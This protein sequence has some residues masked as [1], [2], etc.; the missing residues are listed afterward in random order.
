MSAAIVSLGRPPDF[1]APTTVATREQFPFQFMQ[2]FVIYGVID[3]AIRSAALEVHVDLP[4]GVDGDVDRGPFDFARVPGDY[5]PESFGSGRRSV[6]RAR[7]AW[8]V[9]CVAGENHSVAPFLVLAVRPVEDAAETECG[10]S[11]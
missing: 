8:R 10:R 2:R 3:V 5:L 4:I 1:H 6:A 7:F 9:V 11:D